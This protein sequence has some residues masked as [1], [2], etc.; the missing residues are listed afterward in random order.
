[1]AVSRLGGREDEC[2]ADLRGRKEPICA[3]IASHS[4][5]PSELFQNEIE[6]KPV[7]RVRFSN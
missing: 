1:M 4:D 3:Y 2:C 7:S 5:N 6:S